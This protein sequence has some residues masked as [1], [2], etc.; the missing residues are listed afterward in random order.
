[1]NLKWNFILCKNDNKSLSK[2]F[3]IFYFQIHK[4]TICCIVN[5]LILYNLDFQSV[6]ATS[7]K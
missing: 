7:K 5:I 6:G 2:E 1:M 4:N 3:M